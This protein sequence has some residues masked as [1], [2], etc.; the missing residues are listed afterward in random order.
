MKFR[1]GSAVVLAAVLL[2]GAAVVAP[3]AQAEATKIQSSEQ[4]LLPTGGDEVHDL[5]GVAVAIDGKTMVIG[6]QGADGDGFDTGVVFIFDRSA[7]GWVQTA[8]LFANDADI[9]QRRIDIPE[10][11]GS[12]DDE[13]GT[14]V[15][16]SG[17]TVVVGS[18]GHSTVPSRQSSG[19]V[20]VFQRLPGG[21]IQQA[22]LTAPSPNTSGTF[23]SPRT[24]A[25]SGDMIAVGN[26]I[27]NSTI[28]VP[29]VAVYT[30]KNGTWDLTATLTVPDDP[31]FSPD[32][33]AI[34]GH[35][36]V[37]GAT[38][39]DAPSAPF[40]GAAYVFRFMEEG[41][42]AGTW[43]QQAKLTATDA[44]SSS[45]FGFSVGV[46]GN[47]VVVGA[48]FAPGATAQSGAAY[49]FASDDGVWSQKA[50]LI[51]SGGADGDFFGLSV[52][53]DS[54]TVVVSATGHATSVASQ[55]G[56]AYIYRRL[57]GNWAQLAEVSASDGVPGG[58]FGEGVAI[59]GST[60]VIGAG[61]QNANVE[62]Y[63][64]GEAYVYR[65]NP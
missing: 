26:A 10:L 44:N 28:A 52:A 7:G 22:E 63:S 30:R 4:R 5:F 59:Q 62:G 34:D 50:K 6:A 29:S 12:A 33:V 8:R 64:E 35:T 2:L 17:D 23:G 60:L 20:Y 48:I 25:I 57:N 18:P 45:E 1:P 11:P 14:S 21:W 49:V 41:P 37:V 54:G 9:P 32:S 38:I 19:N 47:V 53:V 39:S 16:I 58:T 36:L 51:G 42:K 56:S 40:A 24:L 55:A 65:L 13:F 31:L 61:G 3:P 27:G 43:V 15:G 46:R